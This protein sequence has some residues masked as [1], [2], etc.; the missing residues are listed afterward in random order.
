V[1]RT[2]QPHDDVSLPV[3]EGYPFR[4]VTGN[5]LWDGGTVF[6]ATPQ[7]TGLVVQ[8]ARLHPDD[9]TALGLRECDA[10]EIRSQSGQVR[11]AL[12]V[13]P[14]VRP[15]TVFVPFSLPGVPVG[16]LFDATGPRPS[17]AISKVS[18]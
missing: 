8:A 16:S 13:D 2:L 11:T 6:A 10:V 3:I 9:A 5:V 12:H 4:L 18:A 7:M 17:V 1:E 14:T 15:G